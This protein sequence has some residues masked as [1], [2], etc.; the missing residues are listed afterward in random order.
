MSRMMSRHGQRC[1]QRND[2]ATPIDV[3]TWSGLDGVATP[4]RCRDMML[5]AL[6]SRHRSEVATWGQAAWAC[7]DKCTPSMHETCAG[8]ARDMRATSLLCAQQRP[9][10]GHWARS[11]RATWV[12]G[13]RTVHPT[14]FCDSALFRVTVWTL[15]MDT[16][17]RV[18]KKKSTKFLKFFLGVI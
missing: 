15:F 7:R 12:L 17:H 18:K 14:Q 5:A 13:V 3:A 16:V 9:R 11:V 10:H 8:C 6:M 4:I 2:V 1:G